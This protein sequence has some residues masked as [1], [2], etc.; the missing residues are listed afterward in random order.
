M[1]RY[2]LNSDTIFKPQE[3]ATSMSLGEEEYS[4]RLRVVQGL[5]FRV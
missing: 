3:A 2:M 5:G 1:P 4:L